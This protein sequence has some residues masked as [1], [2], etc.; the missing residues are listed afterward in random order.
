MVN[1]VVMFYDYLLRH[2]GMKNQL[3]E[4]LVR[5]V[6]NPGRNYRASCMGLQRIGW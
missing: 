4:K 1:T 2:E 5:F 3:P 6:R